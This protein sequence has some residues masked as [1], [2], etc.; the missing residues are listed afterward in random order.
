VPTET[1]HEE[2][3]PWLEAELSRDP[4]RR[5]DILKELHA[6][7]MKTAP[8]SHVVL[9]SPSDMGQRGDV[10]SCKLFPPGT[11]F[12]RLI[13][14]KALR[15][16]TAEEIG[17]DR[18]TIASPTE[19]EKTS[20]EVELAEERHRRETLEHDLEMERSQR[21]ALES[22]GEHLMAQTPTID[23]MVMQ[24]KDEAIEGLRTQLQA[25]TAERDRLAAEA[26]SRGP[27][28]GKRS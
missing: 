6:Q 3:P 13:Y 2:R 9:L 28:P 7:T 8:G 26:E 18:V 25:M 19:A 23:P 22:R 1:I 24:Q 11:D 14:L 10:V 21:R 20:V 17:Q 15:A 27:R 12:G 4:S 5:M 16:A